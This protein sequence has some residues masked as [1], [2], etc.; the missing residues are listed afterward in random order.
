[1]TRSQATSGRRWAACAGTWRS[2]AFHL[3]QAPEFD[4]DHRCLSATAPQEL[5]LQVDDLDKARDRRAGLEL[6][7]RAQHRLNLYVSSPMYIMNRR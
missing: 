1:M 3:S 2:A 5:K 7:E 4:A 6:I